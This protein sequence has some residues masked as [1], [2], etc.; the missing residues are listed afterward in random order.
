ML[1]ADVG[2]RP[3]GGGA[4]AGFFHV[5]ECLDDAGDCQYGGAESFGWD[6]EAVAGVLDYFC[7]GLAECLPQLVAD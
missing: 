7:G 2:A 4:L 6:G 1:A 5:G 3:G